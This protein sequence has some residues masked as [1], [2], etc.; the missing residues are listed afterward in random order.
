MEEWAMVSLRRRHSRMREGRRRRRRRGE[1]TRDWVRKG[2]EL[3]AA[4]KGRVLAFFW[5]H[6]Y[7]F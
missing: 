6:T 5:T 2:R 1:S 7:K 4:C 3:G